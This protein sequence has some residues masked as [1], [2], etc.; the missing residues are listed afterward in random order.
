MEGAHDVLTERLSLTSE[1]HNARLPKGVPDELNPLM[2]VN[3]MC[4]L[5]K[6]FLSSH[7]GFDR[8]DL[9]GY[10]DLFAVAMNPPADK[11]EKAANVFDRVR[12]YPK[13][14]RY[15]DFYRIKSSSDA[16][17]RG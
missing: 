12:R 3:R 13:A 8:D 9:Q 7:S 1:R 5:P 11:M 10:L 6:R 14:M 17:G 16:H 4:F 2:P 15:R